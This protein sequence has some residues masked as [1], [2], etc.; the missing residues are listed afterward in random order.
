MRRKRREPDRHCG[1]RPGADRQQRANSITGGTGND[2]L[3]GGAGND[4][5]TAAAAATPRAMIVGRGHDHRSR[6]RHGA[7]GDAQGDTV[8]NIENLVGSAYADTLAGNDIANHLDGGEGD[9]RMEGGGR[10]S[11]RCATRR[12]PATASPRSS[13]WRTSPARLQTGQTL[14]GNS[15]FDNYHHRRRLR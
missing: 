12:S 6:G 9:D 15:L 3:D 10:G 2:T 1:H 4:M 13:M 11:T 7:G 14:I 8:I 5:L